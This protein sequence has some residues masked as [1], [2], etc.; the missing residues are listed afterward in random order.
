MQDRP[1]S[2]D[3]A[4]SLPDTC[5]WIVVGAGFTGTVVAEHLARLN[6]A[7]V[8]VLDRRDHIAGNA[9]DYPD[10]DGIQIHRH[11]PH[12]FHTNSERIWDYL[13]RFTTW[14]EY[15][16]RTLASVDGQ[17]VPVPFN[18]NSIDIV[19][20][21]SGAAL[22]KAL[23]AEFGAGAR[24]PI[25]RMRQ[26]ANADAR[27]VADHVHDRFFKNYVL[28]QYR[29]DSTALNPSLT[30]RTPIALDRDDRYFADTY[31]G[32]PMHGYAAMF[33]AMLDHPGITVRTG[34]DH[35]A[36]RRRFPRA[37][38]VYTGCIDEYFGYR[39][40]VLPY[41]SRDFVFRR[42]KQQR[43]QAAATISFPNDHDYTR[44]TELSQLTGQ[45]PTAKATVLL[46]EYAVDHIPGVNEPYYPVITPES[47]KMLA[48]YQDDARALAGSV[49]FAGRLG[50]FAY[51]NMDQACA[52]AMSLHA[53]HLSAACD[54]GDGRG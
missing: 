27:M 5:D 1:D 43:V 48:R 8:L 38:V 28:K 45:A 33:A 35:H 2:R 53:K 47:Q 24:V 36:A 20:P 25:Q 42:V 22:G 31:Q 39:H 6:G 19:F 10:D 14:D 44:I 52:R 32:M 13:A 29:M 41:R 26:S 40:G 12:I 51:Y 7:R 15:Y 30:S 18:L 49:W 3:D 11:G 23:I 37:R 4:A 9:Y 54:S 16:H 50:D 17:L 21:D 34:T 46:E